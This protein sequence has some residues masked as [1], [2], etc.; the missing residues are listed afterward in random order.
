MFNDHDF[1]QSLDKSASC[2]VLFMTCFI[3]ELI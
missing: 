2:E 1:K 3:S